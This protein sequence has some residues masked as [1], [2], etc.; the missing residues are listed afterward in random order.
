M[1]SKGTTT[2]ARL[3]RE[4]FADHLPRIRGVS[5]NTVHSYRD[6]L[7]LLIRFLAA[8]HQ[9]PVIHLDF[10]DL[11]PDDVLAFLDHLEM[12]RGNGPIT[13]NARLA[14]IASRPPLA[15]IAPVA[16]SGGDVA[17]AV[18]HYRRRGI[19]PFDHDTTGTPLAIASSTAVDDSSPRERSASRSPTSARRLAVF[20]ISRGGQS[21][22]IT[23]KGKSG[24]RRR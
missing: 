20:Q 17:S 10:A 15:K 16:G 12:T 9:R 1:K 5:P 24:C 6:A 8:L 14:A 2:L 23:I 22:A 21:G 13:R 4:F 3:L 19:V 7:A 11:G 18:A